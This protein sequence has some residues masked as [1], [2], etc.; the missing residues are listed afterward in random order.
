MLT[1]VGLLRSRRF[2]ANQAKCDFWWLVL[3]SEQVTVL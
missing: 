1:F 3:D 2:P